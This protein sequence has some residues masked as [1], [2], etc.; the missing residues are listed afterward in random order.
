MKTSLSLEERMALGV[1]V[2]ANTATNQ[3]AMDFYKSLIP[4]VFGQQAGVLVSSRKFE[5]EKKKK[6]TDVTTQFHI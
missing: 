1:F 2:S 6:K 3:D 4:N 5:P